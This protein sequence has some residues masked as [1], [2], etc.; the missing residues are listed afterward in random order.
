MEEYL[1]HHQPVAL[2]HLLQVVLSDIQV[3]LFEAGARALDIIDK[4][5]TGPILEAS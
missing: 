3:S 4:I 1:W 2:N 5:I